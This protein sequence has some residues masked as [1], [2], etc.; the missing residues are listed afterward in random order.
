MARFRPTGRSA[1]I[2]R[3]GTGWDTDLHGIGYNLPHGDPRN[4][5]LLDLSLIHI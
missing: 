5:A 2:G 4:R 3:H 1:E